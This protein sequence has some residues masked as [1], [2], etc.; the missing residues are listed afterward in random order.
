LRPDMTSLKSDRC[1]YR[2]AGRFV[3]LFPASAKADD[4]I[5]AAT[6]VPPKTSHPLWWKLS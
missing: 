6:D 3:T 2:F 5:G 4:T 1:K